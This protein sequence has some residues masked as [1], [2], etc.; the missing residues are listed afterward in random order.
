MKVPFYY[1][2][3]N[4]ANGKNSKRYVRRKMTASNPISNLLNQ[5]FSF[6][7]KL[8]VSNLANLN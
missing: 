8:T 4:E 1:N 3:I 5:S 7:S 2:F 6:S